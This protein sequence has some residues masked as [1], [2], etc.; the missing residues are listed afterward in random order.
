MKVPLNLKAVQAALKA[1]PKAAEQQTSKTGESEEE[2]PAINQAFSLSQV[3]HHWQAFFTQLKTNN[4]SPIELMLA[5][6]G[7]EVLD[8]H[9]VRVLLNSSLQEEPFE[10]LKPRLQHYLRQQLQNGYLS[11]NPQLAED[12]GPRR[13]Y[14]NSEKF[15]HLLE[16]YPVLS[17]L[18][19]RLG[20]EADF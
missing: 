17:E 2:A 9:E 5:G 1:K 11:L 15:Q 12:N 7:L 13:L 14:T 18:K 20:L 10:R 8:K 6:S 19:D 3:Q 4:G 16:R